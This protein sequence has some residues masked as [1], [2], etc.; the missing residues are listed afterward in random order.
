MK[1]LEF[2]VKN[3][4][5]NR[6]GDKTAPISGAVNYFGVSVAFDEDFES[7]PGGKSVEFYKNKA[8]KRE[9]LVDGKCRIPNEILKDKD[10]FEM[11]VVS[12]CTVATPW[13]KI[14]ITESGP[15]TPEEPEEEAPESMEYVKTLSGDGAAPFLRITKNVLEYSQDGKKFRSGLNGVPEV[16]DDGKKYIRVN[17]DWI[18]YEEPEVPETPDMTELQEAAAKI[19]E[20]ENSVKE[21]EKIE[22]LTGAA[23][24]LTELADDETDPA[25]I[26]ASV[27]EIIALLKARGIATS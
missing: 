22:G 7:I 2:E 6:I 8:T 16:P 11:R 12:G 17:G 25:A 13:V 24:A 9:P 20:L 3:M 23:S 15:I 5:L 4:T 27:N 10:A 21:L 19:P 1:Y 18:P 14:V 26:S